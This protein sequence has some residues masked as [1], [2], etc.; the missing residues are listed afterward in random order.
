MLVVVDLVNYEHD[1]FSRPSQRPREILV[2]G[3][4]AV[5]GIDNKQKKVARVERLVRGLAHLRHEVLFARTENS[6]GVPNRERLFSARTDCRDSI[7]RD[8][9]LIMNDRDFATD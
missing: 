1:R 9:G 6:A 2:D 3:R 8:P 7:A 5:L 4:E